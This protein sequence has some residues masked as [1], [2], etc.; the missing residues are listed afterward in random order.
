[1]AQSLV[2]QSEALHLG[3][4]TC[5]CGHMWH[6]QQIM[7]SRAVELH[8][9]SQAHHA[10]AIRK[11]CMAASPGCPVYCRCHTTLTVYGPGP[12][13]LQCFGFGF[14]RFF[15][16]RPLLDQCKQ[17]VRHRIH[18]VAF[19]MRGLAVP[20]FAGTSCLILLNAPNRAW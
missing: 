15:T 12:P 18:I 9:F 1:M 6:H 16:V 14:L 3:S 20:E 5:N 2:R 13:F 8:L 19:Q 11:L 17:C 7:H 4:D 10:T